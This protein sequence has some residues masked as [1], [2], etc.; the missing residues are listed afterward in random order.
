MGVTRILLSKFDVR[1]PCQNAGIKNCTMGYG[2]ISNHDMK[3]KYIEILQTMHLRGPNIW[4]YRPVF[5]AWVD[6]GELEDFPSNTLPGF[7]ER[8]TAWLPSLIEHRCS[9]GT[10]G[11]FLLRLQEGT[12]PAHILEH[13]TLELQN[14]A[15]MAGG[16][17]RARSTAIRG[18]YKVVVRAWHPE[19]TRAALLA[20]RDLVMAAILDQPYDVAAVVSH[21]RDL[22]DDLLLGP[23]TACIVDAATAKD[24][25]IPFI[26]LSEGNLVQ[27][28]YGAKSRRIWTAE[29]DST[30][31]IAEGISRDKDLTKSLLKSCG[32]PVPEG[33]VVESPAD[34]WEA[35]QEIGLPIVVKPSDANH[36]RGVSLELSSQSDIEAA[37]QVADA[38]GTEVIVERFIPG[39]EH[40]L[41]VVGGKLVAAARGDSVW[42]EGDGRATVAELIDSQI[43]TDPRRGAAEQFPLDT[44]VLERQ[45]STC[46]LLERQGMSAVAVPASGQRVLI[47]RNGNMAEDITEKV[48][49]SVAATV[50]LAARVIGL[51]IA[52]VDLVAEDISRPLSDQGGAIVEVNAGPGLLMHL[53][54]ANGEAR[55]VGR[56]IVDYL[57]PQGESGRIPVVGVTG[58]RGMTAVA[59]R[60]AW[61]IQ[62][63]GKYVGLACG[64]GLY[65]DRRQVEAG[66]CA[67]F[68]AAQR[69][70]MNRMVEAAVFEN[71]GDAILSEGLA[72]DRCQV[73]VV[74]RIDVASH[75]GR[76]YIDTP[77][78]V[79]NV[80][81][82]QVDLVL[83]G[84]VAV[85][86]AADS[87]AVQM[88]PLCDGEVI[89]FGHEFE[90]AVIGEH[91]AK[92]GRAVFVRE[93]KI[94]L[95]TG[96]EAHAIADLAKIPMSADTP[97]ID[98]I[99]NI[100][101]AIG[102]AWALGISPDV[103]R[104]GVK[105]FEAAS[106]SAS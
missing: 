22:A 3:K 41:L 70:L 101:A 79:Y 36:G 98:Q 84:G 30:G 18:V 33:R 2:I 81:R 72:Y 76:Y 6:I 94:I 10:R 14:L 71:D 47:E 26:R 39:A 63:S 45:P 27:L 57:F 1:R 86:N 55:P 52:G 40:R 95:A 44:I 46:L 73:G 104:T 91:L 31:A 34:A 61:L 65:M 64:N 85:L 21:L 75:F 96:L 74:T 59:Q 56:A 87:L 35:A 66:N 5:E 62:L 83:P 89:F 28:G 54:P 16:F 58:S 50:A 37:Y 105:T 60:L 9:E 48:H 4:T 53:K 25:R 24:R 80:L 103:I 68:D 7:N 78:Q 49:P 92:G 12:W 106:S 90:A 23:S 38:E 82:T 77:E 102:A 43:N 11:G 13:V 32:V 93:R 100:L 19:A 97:Q 29:T 88:A 20:G 42:I 51:D 15:G 8:L 69:I 17:G 99:E 67:N